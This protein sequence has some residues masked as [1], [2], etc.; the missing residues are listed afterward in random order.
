MEKYIYKKDTK[1]QPIQILLNYFPD[2]TNRYRVFCQKHV[3]FTY[4]PRWRLDIPTPT[5]PRSK[6]RICQPGRYLNNLYHNHYYSHL[7]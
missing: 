5:S 6:T 7:S 2:K 1:F 3:F 4:H